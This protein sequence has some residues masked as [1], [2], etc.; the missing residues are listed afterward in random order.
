VNL[1]TSVM[2]LS[3]GGDNWDIPLNDTSVRCFILEVV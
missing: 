2:A 1:R 3:V